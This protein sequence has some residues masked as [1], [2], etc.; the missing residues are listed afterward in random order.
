[1][2]ARSVNTGEAIQPLVGPLAPQGFELEYL[3]YL[4]GPTTQR[5]RLCRRSLQ[6]RSHCETLRFHDTR[7][8]ESDQTER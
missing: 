3:H 5:V 6:P 8:S 2:G 1:L 4:G 7:N